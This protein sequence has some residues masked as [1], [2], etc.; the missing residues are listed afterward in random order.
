VGFGIGIGKGRIL[1][2]CGPLVLAQ[3]ISKSP[4]DPES[5][6]VQPDV[7]SLG[8]GIS[9]HMDKNEWD[10]AIPLLAEYAQLHP[11]DRDAVICQTFAC[12]EAGRFAES[13]EFW[14]R[15]I[16]LD[17]EDHFG[18]PTPFLGRGSAFKNLGEIGKA[19]ADLKMARLNSKVPHPHGEVRLPNGER[20]F[21]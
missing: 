2:Y 19:D 11:N 18:K 15:A 3:D 6:Y 14:S 5:G 7:S 10:I 17:G 16:E 20:L 1:S 9:R 13:V 21:F 12:N 4:S 8:A